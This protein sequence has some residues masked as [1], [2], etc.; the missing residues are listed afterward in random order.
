MRVNI[1]VVFVPVTIEEQMPSLKEGR[2]DALLSANTSERQQFLDFSDAVL[3]T[4]RAPNPTPESLSSLAGKT[5]VTPRAGPLAG[6][7]RKTAPAVNLVVTQDYE[8][9]L[10]RLIAGEADAAALNFSA[11]NRIAARLYPSQITLP[12]IMFDEQ[13]FAVGVLKGQSAKMLAE[14]NAGLAAIRADGTWRQLN[15]RWTGNYTSAYR[16]IT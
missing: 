12:R 4:V 13:P 5:V 1:D 6:F 16:C 9:S 8:E 2:A 11:G 10:A 7:I 14:L 3:M 15:D